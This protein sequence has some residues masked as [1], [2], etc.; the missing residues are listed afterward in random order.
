MKKRVTITLDK[1]VIKQ[2]KIKAIGEDSNL[3]AT[4][5]SKS[6]WLSTLNLQKK[7][8]K[9]RRMIFENSS[10]KLLHF[11]HS[12]ELLFGLKLG[13]DVGAVCPICKF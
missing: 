2:A 3:S 12:W 4:I 6:Y 9:L 10:K 5:E 1:D 7:R 11:Y 13:F 8:N